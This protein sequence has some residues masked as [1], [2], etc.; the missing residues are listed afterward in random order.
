MVVKLFSSVHNLIQSRLVKLSICF[1]ELIY[2]VLTAQSMENKNSIQPENNKTAPGNCAYLYI[3]K[4]LLYELWKAKKTL[5]IW[6]VST[7]FRPNTTAKNIHIQ[8]IHI[9]V[10]IKMSTHLLFILQKM[11]SENKTVYATYKPFS[12]ASH[13]Q[14]VR[15]INQPYHIICT[16]LMSCSIF[17]ISHSY[18]CVHKSAMCFHM[19]FPF[20][21]RFI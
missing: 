14:E 6:I 19:P 13:P 10:I 16:A 15:T 5:H 11:Y 18:I 21:A 2:S 20:C 12:A 7:W 3:F 4:I 1:L 17:H 8:H 9:E